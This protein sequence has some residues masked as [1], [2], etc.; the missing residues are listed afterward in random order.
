MPGPFVHMSVMRHAARE[1][2]DGAYRPV[3]S[4]R[5]D[6]GWTGP[7]PAALGR[8]MQRGTGRPNFAAV[9]AL[10]P[11]LFV[12]LPDFR[13]NHGIPVS[14]ILIQILRFLEGVY[15]ALDPYV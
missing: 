13:D 6:P 8:L 5:I 3:A 1:L 2:A 14:S 4:Q 10:G 9:G 7:D 15:E 11:D 12:F